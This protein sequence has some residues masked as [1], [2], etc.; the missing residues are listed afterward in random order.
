MQYVVRWTGRGTRLQLVSRG[1][2]IDPPTQPTDIMIMVGALTA[3][4]IQHGTTVL[5]MTV[6]E[7][8]TDDEVFEMASAALIKLRERGDGSL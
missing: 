2:G 5:A 6:F 3:V 4:V 1:E 7:N 8:S